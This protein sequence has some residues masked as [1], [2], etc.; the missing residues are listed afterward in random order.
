MYSNVLMRPVTGRETLS[1]TQAD[2][3]IL[4]RPA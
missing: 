1:A 2:A 3:Q 4:A